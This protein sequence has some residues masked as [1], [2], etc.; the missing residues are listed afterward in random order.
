MKNRLIV[1]TSLASVALGVLFGMTEQHL[2]R[3]VSLNIDL[4]PQ[5]GF[6]RTI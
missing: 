6:E 5:H 3:A 4:P 2:V 1:F